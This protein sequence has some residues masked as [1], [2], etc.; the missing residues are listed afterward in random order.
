MESK[1]GGRNPRDDQP[2]DSIISAKEPVRGGE[3][4]GVGACGLIIPGLY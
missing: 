2:R 3:E 4:E 1:D